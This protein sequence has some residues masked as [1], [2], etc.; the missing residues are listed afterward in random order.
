MNVIR[1]LVLLFTYSVLIYS[2]IF[3]QKTSKNLFIIERNKNANIV[4]YDA[5]LNINGSI[6][7][8][9]PIDA[10][11]ILCEKQGQRKEIAAFEK[12]V[13]GYTITLNTNGYY[14]LILKAVP[15]K[16]I[17][18]VMINN[19]PKAK[20]SINTKEAYLSKIYVFAKNSFITKVLYYTIT[21]TD[22]ET[23]I[24]IVEKIDV[25]L[26]AIEK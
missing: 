20:I 12:K 19:E 7:E 24:K 5:K 15:R 17:K 13:Y 14:D 25:K 1:I 3:A 21:G 23:G 22:I 16:N 9:N 11:W 8:V 6:D 18:I 10:Y 4:V 2:S 26:N